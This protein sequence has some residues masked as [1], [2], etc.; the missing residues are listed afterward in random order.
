MPAPL[1]A[2]ADV[3]LSID[4]LPLAVADLLL[5]MDALPAAVADELLSIGVAGVLALAGVLL[6]A[7]EEAGGVAVLL[8]AGA[9]VD[10]APTTPAAV[11]AVAGAG[12]GFE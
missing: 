8:A 6:L 9:Y 11:N 5:F 1:A 12:P 4:V 7:D 10:C 2:V 3:L